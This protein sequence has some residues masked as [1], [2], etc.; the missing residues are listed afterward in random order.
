MCKIFEMSDGEV[1]LWIEQESLH[2]R[3]IEAN[4]DPVELTKEEAKKLAEALVEFCN[5]ID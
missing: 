1:R 4:G 3:A 5:A 2:I